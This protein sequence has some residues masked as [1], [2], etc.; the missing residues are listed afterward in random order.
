MAEALLECLANRPVWETHDLPHVTS[1]RCTCLF[2]CRVVQPFP[3]PAAPWYPRIVEGWL[4][5]SDGF[6]PGPRLRSEVAVWGCCW[7][8]SRKEWKIG[9]EQVIVEWQ[10]QL[11]ILGKSRKM[12]CVANTGVVQGWKKVCLGFPRCFYSTWLCSVLTMLQHSEKWV[13]GYRVKSNCRFWET[14]LIQHLL[15]CWQT[16]RYL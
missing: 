10:K 16:S 11:G 4:Q 13:C 8:S 5:R 14:Q 1:G 7:L 9:R 6:V 12:A 15:L 3:S 2:F